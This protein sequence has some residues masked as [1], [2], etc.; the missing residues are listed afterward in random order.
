M[1]AVLKRNLTAQADFIGQ[2][3]NLRIGQPSTAHHRIDL[4]QRN[5]ATPRAAYRTSATH[6]NTLLLPTE[7]AHRLLPRPL[8]HT[9]IQVARLPAPPMARQSDFSDPVETPVE[10][11][12]PATR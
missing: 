2:H 8:D 10:E 4:H 7:T 1:I 6:R 3:L 12:Q 11:G 9:I 5:N